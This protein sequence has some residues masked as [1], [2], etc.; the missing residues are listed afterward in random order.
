MTVR[1]KSV[2]ELT[3]SPVGLKSVVS[4]SKEIIDSGQLVFSQSQWFPAMT[5]KKQDVQMLRMSN[6]EDVTS[7]SWFVVLSEFVSISKERMTADAVI[8]QSF[9]T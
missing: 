6:V 2:F 3:S 8:Q 1:V 5:T 4:S 7:I 9:Q